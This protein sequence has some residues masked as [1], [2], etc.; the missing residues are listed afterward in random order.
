MLNMDKCVTN[1]MYTIF[2]LKNNFYYIFNKGHRHFSCILRNVE[3]KLF[4]NIF[5]YQLY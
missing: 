2:K 1:R 4:E 5:E 3:I